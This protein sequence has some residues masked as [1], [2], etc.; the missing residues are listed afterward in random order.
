MNDGTENSIQ[1]SAGILPA[2][3]FVSPKAFGGDVRRKEDRGG[4][5]R[6]IN[7]KDSTGLKEVFF[8]AIKPS[9]LLNRFD[10]SEQSKLEM[11]L[12]H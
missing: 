6:T 1:N 5:K 9:N 2:K 7:H 12:F 11:V 10:F 4:A 8:L 3:A